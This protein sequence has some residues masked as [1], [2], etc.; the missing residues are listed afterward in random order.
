M[1]P[2]LA[3]YDH[4][5]V[6]FSGGKDSLAMTL[7]LLDRLDDLGIPRSRVELCHHD[8]DGGGEHFMDWPV[9]PAY[10][11]AVADELGLPIYFSYRA[12]GILG[13]MNR[14]DSPT[15]PVVFQEPS[16]LNRM[17]GG[18]G[19][20][21]TRGKFPQVSPNLA[22]RWCSSAVKIDVFSVMINNQARFHNK[23]I[24]VLTGERAQESSSRANYEQFETH[25]CDSA[26]KNRRV[27]QWR[28]I[29]SWR[30]EQVWEIIQRHGIVPHVAYQLGWGRLSCRTCIFGNANQWATIR[31]AYPLHFLKISAREAQTGFTI[32]RKFSVVELADRGT[33]YAAAL[34]QPELVALG[35]AHEWRGPIRVS[36]DTWKLPAGAYGESAG[37]T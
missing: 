29:H 33:P 16:G 34:S 1:T 28:S 27:D 6:A 8:V 4:F 12:G 19:P 31:A 26:R 7:D 18:K 36:P 21:G 3:S 9:T 22:V 35:D 2:D 20:N 17:V 25:R 11:R 37:P 23:R 14:N 15:A 30:E 24:L 10:C 5:L 32:Q 13:E